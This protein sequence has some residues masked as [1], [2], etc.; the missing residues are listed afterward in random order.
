MSEQQNINPSSTKRKSILPKLIIPIVVLALVVGGYLGLNFVASKIDAK[1][2]QTEEFADELKQLKIKCDQLQNNLQN[3][4]NVVQRTNIAKTDNWR[5]IVIEHL[6]H[7]ADL[8]LNTTR[9]TTLA[10]SFLLMAK[11]Y[12]ITPELSAINHS[13]NKDIA[14]LQ[15]VPVV[16]VVYLILKI[17]ALS[18][19]IDSLPIVVQ[20]FIPAIKPNE[21]EV[22]STVMTLWQSF[23][24]STI[25][26][27]KDI[28]VIRRQVV[29]PLLSPEQE[30]ILR[31]NIQTKL[32]QA[33][34]AVIHRQNELYRTCLEEAVNLFARYFIADSN[35][36]P[37]LRELQQI[38]LRPK[39]PLLTESL[40]A[41]QNFMNANKIQETITPMPYTSLSVK[42]TQSI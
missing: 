24:T 33:E 15:T 19:K 3:L 26:A 4:Q 9:D 21:E 22:S 20:R 34:L 5:S 16:D 29:E 28:V 13:L 37:T 10:L 35:I 27:L 8:T 18:Q 30:T 2:S 11:Q 23:F 41:I 32:L 40:A 36:L 31:L 12:A 38:D 17:E 14:N 39:I 7:M 25:K 1:K 42:G 6:V